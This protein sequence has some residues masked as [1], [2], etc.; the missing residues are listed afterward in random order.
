MFK[1]RGLSSLLWSVIAIVIIIVVGLGLYL[2]T[3]STPKQAT[4]QVAIPSGAKNQP[5]SWNGSVLI[6][7]VYFKPSVLK[8]VIGT[9]NTVVWTNDDSTEHTIYTITVPSGVTNFGNVTLQ[10]GSSYKYTF[11]V[12]G[13]YKY[14]CNIHPWM[15]GEILVLGG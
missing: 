9:N 11:T 8:V 12:P 3:S 14:Y 2:Y 7:D 13:I 10:P 6:S 15:G 1:K 5:P 4:I